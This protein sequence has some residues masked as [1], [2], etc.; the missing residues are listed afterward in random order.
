MNGSEY[1][2]TPLKAEFMLI[3]TLFWGSSYLFMK[4][5]AFLRKIGPNV[6]YLSFF[7]YKEE[8]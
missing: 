6:E 2:H 3:V 4:K 8:K 5:G 1:A 7:T